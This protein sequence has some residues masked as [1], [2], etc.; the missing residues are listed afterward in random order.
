[1]YWCMAVTLTSPWPV[2]HWNCMELGY[3]Y[4]WYSNTWSI[5]TD[6]KDVVGTCYHRNS[7][8]L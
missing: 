7:S 6:S 8:P 5:R 1:M 2:T 3:N 4:I